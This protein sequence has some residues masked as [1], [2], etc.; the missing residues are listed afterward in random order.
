MASV[1]VKVK[2][3]INVEIGQEKIV[4]PLEEEYPVPV[5]AS[6]TDVQVNIDDGNS[7][8]AGSDD[9]IPVD[10]DPVDPDPEPTDPVEPNEPP[11]TPGGMLVGT[12][13]AGMEF[14]SKKAPGKAW[15]D[16]PYIKTDMVDDWLDLASDPANVIFRIP[17]R[18]ERIQYKFFGGLQDSYLNELKKLADYITGKGAW[19]VLD[20]H[21]YAT[22]YKDGKD[23]KLGKEIPEGAFADIWERLA[24]IFDHSKVIYGLMNEP[25]GKSGYDLQ[26]KTWFEEANE[27]AQA[28]RA[29]GRG[30]IFRR[31]PDHIRNDQVNHGGII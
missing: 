12:N 7:D 26:S 18:W 24:E 5:T 27:A 21:N 29:K 19:A 20:L 28:I 16:Y 11:V 9:P 4:I 13:L 8:P 14:T 25:V 2:G 23:L 15:T 30:N 22:Y 3:K 6:I 31:I 17:F 10:P 1:N